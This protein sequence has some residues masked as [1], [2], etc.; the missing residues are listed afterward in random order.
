MLFVPVLLTACNESGSDIEDTQAPLIQLNGESQVI[1][2]QGRPYNELGATATDIVDGIVQV[3]L[4]T[5]SVNTDTLGDYELVYTASDSQGNQ[6]TAIRIISVVEPRPF[7]TTW[8]T[9][10]PGGKSLDNQVTISTKFNDHSYDYNIDWG[11]GHIDYNQSGDITHT[12]AVAGTYT[13]SIN[14]TFP[15]LASYSLD[16]KKLQTL[17]QWGD[18]KWESLADTFYGAQNLTNNASDTPDLRLVT[19]FDYMFAEASLF[20]A[21]LSRWDVSNV[22]RFYYMFENADSFTGDI[23]SWDISNVTNMVGMFNNLT[24][25]TERYDALLINWSKQQVQNNVTFDA[26]N[27]QFSIEA[28]AA[29]DILVVDKNWII[30]DAGL[31]P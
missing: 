11:D 31:A 5:T 30:D 29:R 22:T 6:S 17:E 9:D 3:K 19:E 16:E 24:L 13:I 1:I 2:G 8:K 12:Y 21:D 27:S 4:P 18:I 14:D 7:I 20:N 10:T 26:D 23:S 28:Q 15:Q 25:T